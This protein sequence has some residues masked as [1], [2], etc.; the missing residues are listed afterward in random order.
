MHSSVQLDY[1]KTIL[2]VPSL[3]VSFIQMLKVTVD[4]LPFNM[5]A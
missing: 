5:A 4:H 2:S 1:V 3:S